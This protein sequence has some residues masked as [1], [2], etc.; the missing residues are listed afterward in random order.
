[1][2]LFLTFMTAAV[3]HLGFLNNHNNCTYGKQGQYAFQAKFRGDRADRTICTILCKPSLRYG[4]L[5]VF[6]M[7]A[8]HC[9]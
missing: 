2:K 7:S 6:K 8:V 4:N 5:S 1:M 3:R 9:L